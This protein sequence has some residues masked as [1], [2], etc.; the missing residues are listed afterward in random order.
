MSFVRAQKGSSMFSN[1][2]K[3]LIKQISSSPFEDFQFTVNGISI[4]CK[5]AYSGYMNTSSMGI[6]LPKEGEERFY[7]FDFE[8]NK[9]GDN[10]RDNAVTMGTCFTVSC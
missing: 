1:D 7:S 10:G 6:L 5:V 4:T 2:V 8:M 3:A 9:Y